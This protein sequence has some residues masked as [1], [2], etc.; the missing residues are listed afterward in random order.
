MPLP[1]KGAS[2]FQ[3]CLHGLAHEHARVLHRLAELQVENQQLG[4]KVR[5]PVSGLSDGLQEMVDS[6]VMSVASSPEDW[7]LASPRTVASRTQLPV[8]SGQDSLLS[9][10]EIS[11]H[12]APKLKA[13]L[14]ST[15]SRN[16]R[17]SRRQ[18]AGTLP[19]VVSQHISLPSDDVER[20][21]SHEY[22][23]V[24]SSDSTETRDKLPLPKPLT[25]SHEGRIL[26][27]I[28]SEGPQ[29]PMSPRLSRP[30]PA[31]LELWEGEI[32]S[33]DNSGLT[34]A[35]KLQQKESYGAH[36]RR[37][38]QMLRVRDPSCV[39]RM[40]L[41]PDDISR[42]IWDFLSIL[43]VGYDVITIPLEAFD[44]EETVTTFFVKMAITSFWFIDIFASFFTG[45]YADGLL[46]MRLAHIARKY[47]RGWL[48]F[49]IFILTVDILLLLVS[50]I[51]TFSKTQSL[52]FI[53][54]A[55][56][57]KTSRLIRTLRIMRVIRLAKFQKLFVSVSEFIQSDELRTIFSL[58]VLVLG[59]VIFNH[60]FAC[61][62]YFVGKE[63]QRYGYENWLVEHGV[64][65]TGFRYEYS[66]SL[67]WSMTQFTPAAMEVHAWNS[68]E[69]VYAI[70]T[71]L[72]AMITFSSF[73]SSI[74]AA[75][76]HLR[77]LKA[78]SVHQEALLQRYFVEQKVT[79]QLSNRVLKF[80]RKA[81]FEHNRC[82]R[83][84]DFKVL[85]MLPLS[86]RYQLCEEI[87]APVVCR[88]PSLH[89]LSLL[90]TDAAIELCGRAVTETLVA[91]DEIIYLPG[92][93][94]QKVYFVLGG[95]LQYGQATFMSDHFDVVVQLK[96]RDW[97]SEPTLWYKWKHCGRMQ[98]TTTAHT[99]QLDP[100]VVSEVAKTN[101]HLRV[102]LAAYAK[103]FAAH[104]QD[105]ED[106]WQS[107]IWLD[108]KALRKLAHR[109][110]TNPRDV[111]GESVPVSQFLSKAMS[112]ESSEQTGGMRLWS[113]WSQRRT[114]VILQG[115]PSKWSNQLGGGGDGRSSRSEA[116]SEATI[117]ISET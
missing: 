64:F 54:V 76:N 75:M 25:V 117:T 74:T 68:A 48:P 37:T 91:I 10:G 35:S 18:G 17:G 81:Y 92:R 15:S 58:G 39:E 113:M 116:L 42:I 90:D 2:S 106:G 103:L 112:T 96:H 111:P 3:E 22:I 78:D 108:I 102:Y 32:T 40:V 85:E 29:P 21:T 100:A 70:C 93:V 94:A 98:A 69:R 60:Y 71:I 46:E 27:N 61:G 19:T 23:V 109:A 20:F 11:D 107:D 5:L 34:P 45:Y 86:L 80:L 26:S 55:R 89:G 6:R 95:E 65:N 31:F 84:A 52:S 36:V 77:K 28:E 114:H 56:I 104:M 12:L 1:H 49:D 44:T 110:F 97:S 62:W 79:A 38:G 82:S 57:S 99:L 4:G 47:S 59:I 66:T 51:I 50:Y 73:V 101:V 14:S 83:L 8:V 9:V 43:V 7:S 88:I 53:G 33:H 72:F 41:R 16:K 24:G 13:T 30:F 105:H 87:F 67:H 115:L 63:G